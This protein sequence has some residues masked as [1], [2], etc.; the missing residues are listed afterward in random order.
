ME[1]YPDQY[2][3]VAAFN[4]TT[5]ELN[6]ELAERFSTCRKNRFCWLFWE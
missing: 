5:M 6:N 2:G 3:E 1:E 4:R